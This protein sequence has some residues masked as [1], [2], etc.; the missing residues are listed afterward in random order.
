MNKLSTLPVTREGFED[1]FRLHL[2]KEVLAFYSA[3]KD[4]CK[5]DDLSQKTKD[6]IEQIEGGIK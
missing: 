3:I 6:I 4:V 5:K 1:M 2:H